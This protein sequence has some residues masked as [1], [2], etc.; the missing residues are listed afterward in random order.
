V[1]CQDDE[2]LEDVPTWIE[3]K[4][5]LE[6]REVGRCSGHGGD[7][8]TMQEG[9]CRAAGRGDAIRLCILALMNVGKVQKVVFT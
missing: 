2:A 6:R 5:Y 7:S 9:R 8:T 4:A 3:G 1:A